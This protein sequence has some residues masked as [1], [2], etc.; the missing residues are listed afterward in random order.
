MSKLT[1]KEIA[2]MAG[3]SP[4]T[5]SFVLNDKQG[6]SDETRKKVKEIIQKTNFKPSLNSRRLF[7]KK[8]YNISLVMQQT[9][10]PFDDLFYFD[11]TKGL[12]EKSKKFGYNLVFADIDM[13]GNNVVLPEIIRRNDTD[14]VVFLADMPPAIINQIEKREIP[15]VVIDSQSLSNEYSSIRADYRL[16]A[17]T[18]TKYLVDMGHRDIA[19]V[20]KSNVPNFYLQVFSGYKDVLDEAGIP[21]PSS[22]IQIDAVDELSAYHCM[23]HILRSGSIPSAVFCATDVFSIGAINCARSMGY[24]VPEDISFASIDDVLLSRYFDPRLTTVSIDMFK[25]GSL[26]MEMIVQK[27]NGKPVQSVTI[28]SDNLIIRDSVTSREPS[29]CLNNTRYESTAL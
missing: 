27:I 28:E 10:S 26:A 15:F 4:T 20:G 1:I 18:A 25:M 12:L 29:V 17:R 16:S 8:S 11:I 24:R 19:F 9:S 23:E 2:K 14:G 13:R 3:V 7:F 22:W 5:V 6:V 21:I